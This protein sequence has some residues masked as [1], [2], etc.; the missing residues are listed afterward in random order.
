MEENEKN[1][2]FPEQ[3]EDNDFEKEKLENKK[4]YKSLISDDE[5]NGKKQINKRFIINIIMIIIAIILVIIGIVYYVNPHDKKA[6][7]PEK[8]I[9]NF[10]K[11][12]NNQDIDEASDLIDSKGYYVLSSLETSAYP[13]FDSYYKNSDEL[14]SQEENGVEIDFDDQEKYLNSYIKSAIEV[15]SSGLRLSVKNIDSCNLIQGTKGLYK[16]R[17]N[18]EY[19]NGTGKLGQLTDV[20]YVSNNSGEYKIIA[21]TFLNDIM[22]TYNSYLT[23]QQYYN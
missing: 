5:E 19:D 6:T 9:Q 15:T 23:Y 14:F 4:G 16:L 10:C 11:Y 22:S 12:F 8:A 18:F 3:L 2:S 13:K 20:V 17:V 1:N 21:G 7:A